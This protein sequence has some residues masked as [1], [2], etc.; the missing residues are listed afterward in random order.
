MY[1]TLLSPVNHQSIYILNCV[2][3]WK[4]EYNVTLFSLDGRQLR[5][6]L[7]LLT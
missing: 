6:L 4:Y 7:L 2:I 1:L 3:S 5:S